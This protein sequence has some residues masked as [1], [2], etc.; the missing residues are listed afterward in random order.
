MILV[1]YPRSADDLKQRALLRYSMGMQ[2]LAQK[3]S[4]ST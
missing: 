2:R 1:I 3:I 4:K